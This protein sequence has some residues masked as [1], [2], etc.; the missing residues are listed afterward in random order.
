MKKKLLVVMLALALVL[1]FSSLAMAYDNFSVEPDA[2]SGKVAAIVPNGTEAAGDNTIDCYKVYTN[3]ET[4]SMV[5]TLKEGYSLFVGS[6]S[7][8]SEQTTVT[9][10]ST[11]YYTVKPT[12]STST[13]D[14]VTCK[15]TLEKISASIDAANLYQDAAG[16]AKYPKS[17]SSFLVPTG[18]KK[19]YVKIT[20]PEGVEYT[21]DGADKPNDAGY[22]AVSI[23]DSTDSFTVAVKVGGETFASQKFTLLPLLKDIYFNDEASTSGRNTLPIKRGTD[24]YTTKD[25][26]VESGWSPVYFKPNATDN[27]D[28][29][30][31]YRGSTKLTADSKG[32][33]SQ[34][35]NSDVYELTIE[36][37]VGE[38]KN[39]ASQTYTL[40]LMAEDYEGP[41][42]KSFE[43]NE[44][45]TGRG[46]DYITVVDQESKTVYVFLPDGETS[47]YANVTINGDIKDNSLKLG[48]K[49]INEGTWNAAG[50]ST[51]QLTYKDEADLDY[52]Y[53]VKVVKGNKKYDDATLKSLTIKSGSRSNTADVVDIGFDPKVTEYAFPV[54]DRDVWLN[55][56]A[57]AND[58]NATVF[59]NGHQA[60]SITETK[61][62]TDEVTEYEILV[63]AGDGVTSETYTVTVNGS[64]GLLQSLSASNVVGLT[65]YFDPDVNTYTAYTAAGINSTYIVALAKNYSSD[66]VQI[67]KANF[68]AYGQVTSY[69]ALTRAVQGSASVTGELKT[70]TN[71]FRVDVLSSASATSAKASYYLVI[72][73]P[74]ADPKC[75]VSSQKLYINGKA[76]TLSAYNIAGNNYLKLRD[77]AALLDGTVKEMKVDWDASKWTA[78]MVMPGTFTKRGDELTTL[79]PPSKYA[80]ST[81]YF[82]YNA[83]P[84]FPLAYNVTGTGDATGSNYVMLRDV[85]SLLDFGVT[86]N[87]TAQTINI[88]TSNEYTP[89]L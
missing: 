74:T 47:F 43:A 15:Y 25:G 83:K 39:T 55:I 62:D 69:T 24:E 38:G 48:S 88:N 21:V 50:T 31:V 10:N 84:V 77:V 49:T 79:T 4:V 87:P 7:S 41:T 12:D 53:T 1:A 82:T 73:V 22:A 42:I 45:S 9:L 20:P 19:V 64:T 81:Q 65:P 32:W 76:Q 30:T 33:F 70:G 58:S 2:G 18:V 13:E 29:V 61:L 71:I 37:S 23:N 5:F 44:L 28:D 34:R 66:Y 89:G 60:T 56:A 3:A 6:S 68:N 85:A 11:E 8:A 75:V 57:K 16:D 27:S 17:G 26:Y 36:V 86:Y 51:G 46:D 72:N 14:P 63:V 52:K 78:S 40:Y 54:T 35:M 80:L 59:I 67:S